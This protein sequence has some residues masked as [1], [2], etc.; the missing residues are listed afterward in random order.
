MIPFKCSGFEF[1]LPAR[2]SELTLNQFYKLKESD[3][4]CLSVISILSNVPVQ[5]WQGCPDIDIRE[6]IDPYLQFLEDSFD[7]ENYFVPDF[8][9]VSGKRYPKPSGIGVNCA[10]QKWHLE[11]VWK[12]AD[13]N[14][15]SDVDCYAQALAIYMQPVVSGKPYD[16]DLVEKLIP[17]ILECK[18][19]EAWP[20]ASFF[21]DSYVKSLSKKERLFRIS[22]SQKRYEQELKDS[23]SSE[24]SPQFSVLRKFLIKILRMLSSRITIQFTQPY[25]LRQSKAGTGIV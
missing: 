18:L 12:E 11:D 13:K 25:T 23:K 16:A 3:G 10:G 4:S 1:E 24:T 19:E 21:L 6:K 17:E 9:T 15:K 20:L 14:G 8:I 2:W 22:Q 7:L 5:A